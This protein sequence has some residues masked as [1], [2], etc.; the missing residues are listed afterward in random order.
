MKGPTV[1]YKWNPV[2][3]AVDV[4]YLVG[5][6]EQ[7]VKFLYEMSAD[8]F[9]R[10]FFN[11]VS[12]VAAIGKNYRLVPLEKKEPPKPVILPPEAPKPPASPLEFPDAVQTVE[13]L[14]RSNDDGEK[15]A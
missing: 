8:D 11:L 9:L 7:D 15:A 6:N 1:F 13:D 10:F 3:G 12:M 5:E 2:K 4:L 14:F